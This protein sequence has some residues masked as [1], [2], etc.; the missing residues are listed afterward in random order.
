MRHKFTVTA[1]NHIVSGWKLTPELCISLE[2]LLLSDMEPFWLVQVLRKDSEL[3]EKMNE[4]IDER[5]TTTVDLV[6]LLVL[7]A[8]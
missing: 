6:S 4:I 2:I 8:N 5:M 3:I 1:Y 7:G